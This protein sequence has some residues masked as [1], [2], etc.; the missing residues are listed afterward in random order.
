MESNLTFIYEFL[1]KFH[2]AENGVREKQKYHFELYSE[3]LSFLIKYINRFQLFIYE[4]K[5]TPTDQAN[6]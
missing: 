1:D 4:L 2:S 6:L 3:K 5:V